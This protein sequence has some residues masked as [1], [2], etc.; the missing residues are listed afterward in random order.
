MQ[1]LFHTFVQLALQIL[2]IML[3]S[4]HEKRLC[5]L[6]AVGKLCVIY[7]YHDYNPVIDRQNWSIR[8]NNAFYNLQ[9]SHNF[10]KSTKINRLSWAAHAGSLN[11]EDIIKRMLDQNSALRGSRKTKI[12][13]DS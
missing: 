13:M 6:Q 9:K 4:L 5:Q 2:M 12:Y 8:F 7:Y 1:F 3:S 11:K 10:L